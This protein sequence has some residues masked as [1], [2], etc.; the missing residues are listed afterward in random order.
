MEG[1]KLSLLKL[2]GY[3]VEFEQLYDPKKRNDYT[4]IRYTPISPWANEN[5]PEPMIIWRR[6]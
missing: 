3:T 6:G 1:N 4:L 2:A 5:E